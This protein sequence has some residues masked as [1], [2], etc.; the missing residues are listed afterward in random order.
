M[1]APRPAD[2]AALRQAALPHCLAA[3]LDEAS[4]FLSAVET[5]LTRRRDTPDETPDLEAWLE[6][7]LYKK[8]GRS[9]SR[10]KGRPAKPR[11]PADPL[12]AAEAGL[13]GFSDDG[14]GEENPLDG[15]RD[16]R[17]AK[18]QRALEQARD[19]MATVAR[20]REAVEQEVAG[21]KLAA[22]QAE[23]AAL[24][25]HAEKLAAVEQE[26]LE[27]RQNSWSSRLKNIVSTTVSTATGVFF[28]SVGQRAGE[29]VTDA[30][31]NN[32]K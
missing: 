4:A 5:W 7:T 28:G 31:F 16:S 25:A 17:A 24:Q 27:Q 13:G 20:E 30:V 11:A 2:Y 10:Q 29:A 3:E 12:A 14:G 21:R 1:T 18:R 26:A 32:K 6:A 15:L 8:A 22:A 23:A 9:G 19:G